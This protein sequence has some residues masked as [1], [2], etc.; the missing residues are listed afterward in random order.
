MAF[1]DGA[2][3]E[4]LSPEGEVLRGIALPVQRPTTCCFGGDDLKRLY[5]T[6]AAVGIDASELDGGLFAMGVKAPGLPST[7]IR[8][9]AI[10]ALTDH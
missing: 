2:R 8:A 5:I 3:V 6:S 1:W 7:S 9:D 4:C 10:P